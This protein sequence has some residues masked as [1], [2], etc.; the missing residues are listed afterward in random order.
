[1]VDAVLNMDDGV[2]H[3]VQIRHVEQVDKRQILGIKRIET[4]L[5]QPCRSVDTVK[6]RRM[7]F[8]VPAVVLLLAVVVVFAL[9][10]EKI[11]NQLAELLTGHSWNNQ[12]PVTKSVAIRS[13]RSAVSGLD[14]FHPIKFQ[15]YVADDSGD[16]LQ[17]EETQRRIMRSLLDVC[18]EARKNHLEPAQLAF[19]DFA[20]QGSMLELLHAEQRSR[21][22]GQL[23]RPLRGSDLLQDIIEDY[24]SN[25]STKELV[26]QFGVLTLVSPEIATTYGISE[27]VAATV[28]R[29]LDAAFQ[30]P[31]PMGQ[32]EVDPDQMVIDFS[33]RI[34][35]IEESCRKLLVSASSIP[36]Q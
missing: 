20:V 13:K 11:K 2:Q 17:L 18:G 15:R 32:V 14:R 12:K 29:Q 6:S 24:S 9:Q 16:W 8:A 1:M 31:L 21:L 19:V 33:L 25:V 26:R 22:E 28:R 7:S 36:S 35:Q 5:S 27:E 23:N 3:E 10:T 30:P 34:K 4:R